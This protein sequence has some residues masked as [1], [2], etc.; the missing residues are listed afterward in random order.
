[1]SI[2]KNLVKKRKGELVMARKIFLLFVALAMLS[3]PA[4]F[5]A[6]IDLTTAPLTK[7][8]S[9]NEIWS[10]IALEPTGTGIFE[11]FLRYQNSPNEKGMNT[12]AK[13]QQVYDDVAGIWTHSLLWS[14]LATTLKNGVT[15]Y[16]FTFDINEPANDRDQYLSID[17]LQLLAGSTGTATNKNQLTSVYT[18]LDKVMTNYRLSG[19]GSGEADIEVLIPV[20]DVSAHGGLNYFYLYIESGFTASY[21]SNDF[22]SEDGFEEVRAQLGHPII[23]EPSILLLLGSGLV[24]IFGFRRFRK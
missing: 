11:P 13:A 14:D 2:N 15:Y 3:A 9:Q 1:M 8:G 20:T 22:T 4:V 24:A 10:V 16:D 17:A 5:A 7:T 6:T 12:D 21:N 19:S 18:S 23:P